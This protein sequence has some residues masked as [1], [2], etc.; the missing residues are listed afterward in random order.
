MC[1]LAHQD[2]LKYESVKINVTDSY[3]YIPLESVGEGLVGVAGVVEED[4]AAEHLLDGAEVGA[5]FK[6]VGGVL[7]Q[8]SLLVI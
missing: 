7:A 2:E 5:A 6:Q 1:F 8:A 3:F 4:F